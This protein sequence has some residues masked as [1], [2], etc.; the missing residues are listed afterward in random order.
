[1]RRA[2]NEWIH[3]VH[4]YQK[5]DSRVYVNGAL[6]GVS[7]N[8]GAPLNIRIPARLW[9]GGWYNNYDFVGDID[10]VRV[11]KVA[12][13]AEW[14]RLEYENQKSMQTLVGP[15]VQKGDVFSV[16]QSRF[17]IAEGKSVTATAQAGGA[18]KLYWI[19]KRDG[20]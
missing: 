20:R 15:V 7:T 14:V 19:L 13:S 12:R 17:T 9:L 8:Q 1:M 6:D 5:G 2:E 18:Q 4:T 10:E 16:S 11:S 3:V